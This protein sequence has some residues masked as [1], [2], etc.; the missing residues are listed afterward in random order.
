MCGVRSVGRL[1]PVSVCRARLERE[2]EQAALDGHYSGITQTTRSQS[3]KTDKITTP[4]KKV[5]IMWSGPFDTKIFFS[6]LPR[7]GMRVR[8][9]GFGLSYAGGGDV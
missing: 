6:V 7:E 5:D 2:R 9:I 4:I 8:S 3:M 1:F